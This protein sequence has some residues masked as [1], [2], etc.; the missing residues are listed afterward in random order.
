MQNHQLNI[1]HISEK[2]HKSSMKGWNFQLKHTIRSLSLQLQPSDS[3]SRI[4]LTTSTMSKIQTR[5]VHEFPWCSTKRIPQRSMP[6]S[7]VQ[8]GVKRHDKKWNQSIRIYFPVS[9]IKSLIQLYTGKFL[10]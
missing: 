2:T 3:F 4:V 6:S 10:I 1:E 9:Q 8:S 7:L 5:K